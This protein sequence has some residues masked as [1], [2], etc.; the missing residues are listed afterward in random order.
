MKG[1]KPITST[2]TQLLI[3]ERASHEEHLPVLCGLCGIK[4]KSL[5]AVAVL[6]RLPY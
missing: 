6:A 3:H 2:S 1:Y 4:L 5:N